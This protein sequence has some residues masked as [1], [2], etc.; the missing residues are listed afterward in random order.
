MSFDRTFPGSAVTEFARRLED[1]GAD[2]L[3]LIEDCFF[4]AAPR[5]GAAALAVTE[6]L[7]ID[8]GI[9]P[10]VARTAAMTAMEIATLSSLAPGRVIGGIGHGVQ[11]WMAKMGAAP[12]SPLTTLEEVLVAVRR[13]LAGEEVNV[14]R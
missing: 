9:L 1:G 4:T 7:T 6:H 13:L 2:E 3:W 10:A 5:L 11:S 14:D 12:P 8:L